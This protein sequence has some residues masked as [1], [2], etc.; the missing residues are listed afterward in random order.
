MLAEGSAAP[1]IAAFIIV[2]CIWARAIANHKS[3]G[4]KFVDQCKKPRVNVDVAVEVTSDAK[5]AIDTLSEFGFS[6]E[7]A[8]KLVGK[9]ASR[10]PAADYKELINMAIKHE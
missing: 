1:G 4:N 7:E 3:V 5:V 6:K 2:L 9:A 10:K 8:S